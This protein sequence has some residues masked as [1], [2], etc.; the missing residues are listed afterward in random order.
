MLTPV[1]MCGGVRDGMGDGLGRLGILAIGRSGFAGGNVG[2][3][4]V[5]ADR[6]V[7]D[8]PDHN[9]RGV[10]VAYWIFALRYRR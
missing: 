10:W 6:E 1:W 2:G 9:C 4:F 5:A 7:D 8:V 3:G